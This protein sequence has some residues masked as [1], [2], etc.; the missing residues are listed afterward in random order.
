M[1]VPL[2]LSWAFQTSIHCLS[3]GICICLSQLLGRDSQ[4]AA[5]LGSSLYWTVV[6]TTVSTEG[7]VFAHRFG[8]KRDQ[9]LISHSFSL[10][11]ILVHE[12]LLDRK[13]WG[14]KVL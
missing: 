9:L 12:F 4:R 3:V 1:G 11:S 2:T 6:S 13:N 10:C 14:S 7:L 5:I 8:L